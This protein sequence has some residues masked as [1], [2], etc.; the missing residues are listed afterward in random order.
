MTATLDKLDG[1]GETGSA[2]ALKKTV[3]RVR[4]GLW[5]LLDWRVV[6]AGAVAGGIVHIAIVFSTPF[7]APGSAYQ[8][9]RDILPVNRV[10]VIQPQVSAN[11]VLPF[12]QPDALY[13]MCRFDL[14]VDSLRVVATLPEPGWTLSLHSMQGDNFYAM[15]GQQKR[16]DVTFVV[17]PGG[18]RGLDVGSAPRRLGGVDLQVMS[19]TLE[20][21]VVV[22]APL[23]GLAY[24][25]ETEALLSR[26]ACSTVKR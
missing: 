12:V 4:P 19:P 17:V 16:T 25:Q 20:G 7:T 18:E 24:R 10:H 6:L 26:T 22:R 1:V 3:R 11:Q 8:R 13:A 9:L 15:A 2:P 14:A 23:K 21:V 5:R